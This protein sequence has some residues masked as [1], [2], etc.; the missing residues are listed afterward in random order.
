MAKHSLPVKWVG[1]TIRWGQWMADDSGFVP[2]KSN[3]SSYVCPNCHTKN[4]PRYI[5][6]FVGR[7]SGLPLIELY[8]RRCMTCGYTTVTSVEMELGAQPHDYVLSDED[9]GDEGT[10]TVHLSNDDDPAYKTLTVTLRYLQQASYELIK[11]STYT[12]YGQN[13]IDGLLA[14][15][16]T[17][18]ADC[19][20]TVRKYRYHLDRGQN[21]SRH[22]AE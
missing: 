4:H 5:S 6:G 12:D 21:G 2:N 20:D 8:L 18:I 10:K 1:D 17:A 3:T 7:K 13:V 9:Y 14:H 16:E 19:T 22:N 15:I 11:Y